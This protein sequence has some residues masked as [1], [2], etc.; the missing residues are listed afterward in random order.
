MTQWIK[1]VI[2]VSTIAGAV[3]LLFSGGQEDFSAWGAGEPGINLLTITHGG[4]D[5]ALPDGEDVDPGAF[6][7]GSPTGDQ[8]TPYDFQLMKLRSPVRRHPGM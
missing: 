4:Q 6:T 1:C 5:D 3:L 8:N 2:V 7:A